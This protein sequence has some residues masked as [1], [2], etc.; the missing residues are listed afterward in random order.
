[1]RQF[2]RAAVFALVLAAG[3]HP[4]AAHVIDPEGCATMKEQIRYL[5]NEGAF[6]QDAGVKN[7]VDLL[8]EAIQ[9]R[10]A[11]CGTP[12]DESI[13]PPN[14][15]VIDPPPDATPVPTPPPAPTPLPVADTQGSFPSPAACLL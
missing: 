14:P 5:T 8:A 10:N 2:G 11:T 9:V 13:P 1:M 12:G 15:A 6:I 7:G 4:V 3:V